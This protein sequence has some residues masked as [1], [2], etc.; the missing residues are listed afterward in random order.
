MNETEILALG[1][2]LA[3]TAAVLRRGEA[4]PFAEYVRAILGRDEDQLRGLFSDP[5]LFVSVDGQLVAGPD[6]TIPVTAE[7]RVVLCRRQGAM[8]DVVTGGAA[9]RICLN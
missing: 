1:E 6:S 7:S 8:L 2:A 9:R 4:I 5:S 3:R